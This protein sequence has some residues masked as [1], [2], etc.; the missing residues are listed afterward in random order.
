M[1]REDFLNSKKQQRYNPDNTSMALKNPEIN[2]PIL[3]SGE[4]Y[5]I[6]DIEHSFST[7]GVST[8]TIKA[9]RA[10]ESPSNITFASTLGWK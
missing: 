8:M 6:T 10:C 2:K 1:K 4:L 7:N 9:S 3:V 5:H